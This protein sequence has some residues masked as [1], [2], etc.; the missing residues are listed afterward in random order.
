[1]SLS[2]SASLNQSAVGRH[3]GHPR[4]AA[5]FS[6]PLAFFSRIETDLQTPKIADIEQKSV[7]GLVEQLLKNLGDIVVAGFKN[8]R[9]L[10]RQGS[11]TK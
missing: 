4:Q 3:S 7:E 1:M 10:G 6:A 8:K 2:F 11:A 9:C 5:R